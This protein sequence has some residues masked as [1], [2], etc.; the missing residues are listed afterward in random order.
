MRLD[1]FPGVRALLRKTPFQVKNS[2]TE[3]NT[4]TFKPNEKKLNRKLAKTHNLFTGAAFMSVAG[5][6]IVLIDA[7]KLKKSL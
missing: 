4:K 6:A 2:L 7:R 5:S 3:M 1:F